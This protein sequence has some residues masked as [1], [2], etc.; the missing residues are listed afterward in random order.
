MR[1]AVAEIEMPADD[2]RRHDEH[3]LLC[4][5]AHQIERHMECR[6][7]RRAAKI[8]VEGSTLR[9]KLLL[10]FDRQ[11][12]IGPLLV[13]RRADHHVDVGSVEP[14]M[15]KRARRRRQA[16]LGFDRNL[17]IAARRNPGRHAMRV[18]YAVQHQHMTVFHA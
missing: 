16:E 7:R 5:R 4:A 17:V 8:H 9:A 3:A 6:S 18:E 12:R 14:G 1:L 13:R 11:R 10:D 2:F 15:T